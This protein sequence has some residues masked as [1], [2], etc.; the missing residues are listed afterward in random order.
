MR[1][2]MTDIWV[3]HRG[4]FLGSLFGLLFSL[5]VMAIGLLWTLFWILCVLI[6]YQVG[7]KMD[8]EKENLVDVLERYLPPGGR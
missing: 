2:T 3:N 7:K 6:G 4:K 8:E 1:E 5:S